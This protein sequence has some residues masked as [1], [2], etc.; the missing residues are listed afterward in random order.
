MSRGVLIERNSRVA[1][2]W[3]CSRAD[4]SRSFRSRGRRRRMRH[5]VI[6]KG[7]STLKPAALLALTMLGAFGA[8]RAD[9]SDGSIDE[10]VVVATR[11]PVP[12]S[13]IGSSIT[14]LDETAIKDSQVT[15]LADLLAQTPGLNVARIGGVGSQT[16]VF[17]RGADSDHTLVVIDGVQINDPSRTD[18]GFDFQD[19]L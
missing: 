3:P 15:L 6:T 16:S 12:V 10:V 1:T 11:A 13:K 19:L 8:A 17:I 14:V 7:E 4:V 2:E 5:G 9:N 18:D